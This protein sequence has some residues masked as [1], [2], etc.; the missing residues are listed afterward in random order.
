ML[1]FCAGCNKEKAK[2]HRGDTRC[3]DCR[4]G[5]NQDRECAMLDSDE[6]NAAFDQEVEFIADR[7]ELPRG[8]FVR[9]RIKGDKLA[10]DARAALARQLVLRGW[11][12]RQIALYLGMSGTNVTRVLA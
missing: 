4:R 2:W 1:K 7:F 5:L 12:K 9:Q 8:K 3:W 11:P 6:A 10:S